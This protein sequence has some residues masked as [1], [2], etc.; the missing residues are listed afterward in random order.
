LLEKIP[1]DERFSSEE[2]VDD[3]RKRGKEAFFFPDTDAIIDYLVTVSVPEDII[4]IMSNGGFD[5]I[6]ERLLERL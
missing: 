3:L 5:N 1:P 4:L 2:L 6:H